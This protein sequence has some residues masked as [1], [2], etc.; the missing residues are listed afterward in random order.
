VIEWTIVFASFDVAIRTGL[1][2]KLSLMGVAMLV[3]AGT[4]TLAVLELDLRLV[5][6]AARNLR[7]H[8]E[9]RKPELAVVDLGAFERNA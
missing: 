1:I 6:A 3:A 7:M 5:A 2:L 4:L 8:S 9:S